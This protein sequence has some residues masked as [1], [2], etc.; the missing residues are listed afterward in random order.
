MAGVLHLGMETGKA[1]QG[2][3]SNN[4]K[5][6]SFEGQSLENKQNKELFCGGVTFFPSDIY[7]FAIAST[8]E[9]V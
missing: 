1:Q 7:A 3:K 9:A 2:D 8:E 4:N 5:K 6:P